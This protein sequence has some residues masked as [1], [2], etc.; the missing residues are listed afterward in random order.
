M[1]EEAEI[2]E[3]LVEGNA[4]RN[5]AEISARDILEL[6]SVELGRALEASELCDALQRIES[7]EADAEAESVIDAATYICHRVADKMFGDCIDEAN[8]EWSEVDI[9]TEWVNFN[10][11]TPTDVAVVVRPA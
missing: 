10:T 2:V 5:K 8:D 9:V 1:R 11:G 4:G 7:G 6:A 3:S